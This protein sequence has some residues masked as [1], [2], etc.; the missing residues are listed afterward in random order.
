M[1]DISIHNTKS[2]VVGELR[3]INGNTPL[4]TRDIIITD[5]RGHEVTIT[6][7]TTSEEGE[8]LRVTL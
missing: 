6:C 1:A 5:A 3:E 2:I 8:E 7:F 4:Y